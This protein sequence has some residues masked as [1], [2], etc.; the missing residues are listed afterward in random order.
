MIKLTYIVR[1]DVRKEKLFS[2]DEIREFGRRHDYPMVVK[3]ADRLIRDPEAVL[4]DTERLILERALE[5][6]QDK[7]GLESSGDY[8]EVE[9]T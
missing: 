2:F 5:I 4:T 6:D 9:L 8:F 1:K 7:L 3:I